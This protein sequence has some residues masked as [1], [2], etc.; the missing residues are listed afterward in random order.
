MIPRRFVVEYPQ[1]CLRL[2]EATEPFARQEKLVG[3]FALLVAS[4]LFTIPYERLNVKHPLS[5]S[6]SST[7]L[8]DALRIVQRKKFLEADFWNGM[9]PGDWRF[10]RIMTTP[11]V[12]S[13][14]KDEKGMHPMHN[15]ADNTIGR[16]DADAVL[17]VIRNALAHGNVVYLDKDGLETV[18]ATVQYLAFLSRYEETPEQ[19]AKSETYRIVA[20]S[21][22]VFLTFVKCWATWL[23][24]FPPDMRLMF[25]DA[26]E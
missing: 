14:W 8:Y 6:T 10:S 2:L 21:E 18:G 11:E 15:D 25:E 13:D 22:E 9:R 20:T 3:S 4:A 23:D 5:A 16:R 19:R 7:E 1:R 26:A 24:S 17:R 12:T